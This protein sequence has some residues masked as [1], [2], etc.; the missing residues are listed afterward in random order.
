[1]R[2]LIHVTER[3]R[4]V[5]IVDDDGDVREN[6]EEILLREGFRP[7]CCASAEE[8]L[9]TLRGKHEP[10]VVLLDLVM[11]QMDGWEFLDE[12]MRMPLGTTTHPIIVVSG[13]IDAK[14]ATKMPGVV[15]VLQKPFEL[16]D[17]IATVREHAAPIG[18]TVR[19]SA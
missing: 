6:L 2:K 5:L 8:A 4:C 7:Q 3:I 19:N 10:C 9:A 15:A 14:T 17:L 16:E 18:D 13:A 1:M 11:P 12:L